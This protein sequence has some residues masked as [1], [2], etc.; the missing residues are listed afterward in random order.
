[1]WIRPDW[2]DVYPK[3]ALGAG[4]LGDGYPLCQD[5]P[6]D[7]FLQQGAVYDFLGSTYGGDALVLDAD[8]D[9][10][11]ALSNTRTSVVRLGQTLT[12]SGDECDVERRG[13]LLRADL[14]V[15]VEAGYY[16][17]VPRPACTHL[18]FFERRTAE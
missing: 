3:P 10:Y 18:F 9:L 7:A 11:Q 13:D 1:M 5:L 17:Y 6:R 8:S 16:E 15:K 4:Y 12:C 2:H 14:V